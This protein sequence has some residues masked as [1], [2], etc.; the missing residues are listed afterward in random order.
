[1]VLKIG[2]FEEFSNVVLKKDGQD[3]FDRSS[4]NEKLLHRVMA[5]RNILHRIKKKGQVNWSHLS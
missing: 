1:M 5:E 3:Q 4:E 2:E